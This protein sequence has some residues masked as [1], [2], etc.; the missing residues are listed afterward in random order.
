MFKNWIKYLKAKY[1]AKKMAKYYLSIKEL[2][3]QNWMRFYEGNDPKH[4]LKHG[5]VCK[6]AGKVYEGLQAELIDEF[7]ISPVF[8]TIIENNI[9]IALLK[10]EI[11]LKGDRTRQIFIDKLLQKN[12]ELETQSPK[13][14]LAE[15]IIAI[16]KHMGFRI[17]LKTLTVYDFYKYSKFVSNNL[18]KVIP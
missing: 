14:D 16:E 12:E 1:E 15:N 10:A 8:K 13:S 9:K 18:T 2:P 11:A 4:L 17:D 7:G 5:K 6:R 3:M